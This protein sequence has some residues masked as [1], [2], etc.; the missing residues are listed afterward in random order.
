M[1]R[2]RAHYDVIEMA[3]ITVRYMVLKYSSAIVSRIVEI[4]GSN[5]AIII[6]DLNL[7]RMLA[8]D[9]KCPQLN[10]YSHTIHEMP[11]N[12]NILATQLHILCADNLMWFIIEFHV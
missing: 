1:R 5:Q 4:Y 3:Q 11:R 7:S 9:A 2:C 6:H 10:R 8:S 12:W